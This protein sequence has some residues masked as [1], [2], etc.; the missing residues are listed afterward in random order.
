LVKRDA[1][2]AGM[3]TMQTRIHKEC[4]DLFI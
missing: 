3:N 1:E 4:S 2:L